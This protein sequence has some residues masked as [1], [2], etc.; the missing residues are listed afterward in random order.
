MIIKNGRGYEL[1]KEMPNTSEDFF[2]RSEITIVS[3]KMEKTFYVLYVRYFE[4]KFREQNPF[5]FEGSDL[6]IK[7][8]MALICII[9][10]ETLLERKR[11]YLN[12]EEEFLMYLQGIDL[13]AAIELIPEMNRNQTMKWSEVVQKLKTPIHKK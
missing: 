5:L 13:R 4:D 6:S 10:N 12:T 2:N 7:D 1:V 3:K 8:V 11:L 9:Q